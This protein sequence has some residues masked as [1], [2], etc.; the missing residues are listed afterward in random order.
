MRFLHRYCQIL[1]ASQN[2]QTQ[3][4]S[5][6]HTPMMVAAMPGD[7]LLIGSN[8]GQIILLK[9]TWTFGQSGKTM[10]EEILK[11]IAISAEFKHIIVVLS[12]APVLNQE[13]ELPVSVSLKTVYFGTPV[14]WN[15]AEILRAS[16]VNTD[17]E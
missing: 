13:L 4:H 5:D 16:P 12:G 7:N 9:D 1:N 11:T 8:L 6:I 14:V 3:I 10:R 17:V 15:T 2:A